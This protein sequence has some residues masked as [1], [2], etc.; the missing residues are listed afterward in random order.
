MKHSG[1]PTIWDLIAEVLMTC[2]KLNLTIEPQ[3]IQVG[4]EVIFLGKLV[5]KNAISIAQRHLDAINS[6]KSPQTYAE[7]RK[8]LALLNFFRD[9]VQGFAVKTID[10][11]SHVVGQ[12]GENARHYL[13]MQEI[14]FCMDASRDAKALSAVSNLLKDFPYDPEPPISYWW[15]TNRRGFE[16]Q[17][18]K[19][20]VQFI[21]RIMDPTDLSVWTQIHRFQLWKY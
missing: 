2:I 5:S 11:A 4:K 14:N 21:N 7:A 13:S 17:S 3:N 1:L 12:R 20:P 6:L 19:L 9:H 8:L 15:S 18:R 10:A 16:Q